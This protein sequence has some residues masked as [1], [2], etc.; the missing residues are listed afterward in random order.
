M[1]FQVTFKTPDAVED[2]I[3]DACGSL[4]GNDHEA[5]VIKGRL[6]PYHNDVYAC[7]QVAEKFVSYG[8]YVTIEFDTE[9]G[10]ATVIPL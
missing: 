3:K 8:E 7:Q 4:P 5:P 9:K 2:S 6:N 1:K 10:T